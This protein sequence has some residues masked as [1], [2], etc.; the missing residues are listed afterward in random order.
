MLSS[1]LQMTDKDVTKV[2]FRK[3]KDN[4]EIIALFVEV[5]GTNEFYTCSAYVHVGQHFAVNPTLVISTSTLA[6]QDEYQDLKEELEQRGYSL[7]VIKRYQRSHLDKR[8]WN[9]VPPQE[10]GDNLYDFFKS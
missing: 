2:I 9:L 8:M 3:M 4:G 6:T 7:K 1:K 5:P 10:M